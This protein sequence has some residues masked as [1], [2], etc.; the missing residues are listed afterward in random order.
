MISA[1]ILQQARCVSSRSAAGESIGYTNKPSKHE[2]V[3]AAGSR[4]HR[5]RRSGLHVSKRKARG[6][7][8]KSQAVPGR[9]VGCPQ[10]MAGCPHTTVFLRSKPFVSPSLSPPRLARLNEKIRVLRATA[11]HR[12][13]PRTTTECYT[14][15]THPL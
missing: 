1:T 5:A 15:T 12:A 10:K 8:Q 2:R 11:R 7:E 13:P 9:A 14:P 4:R 6:G 3:A